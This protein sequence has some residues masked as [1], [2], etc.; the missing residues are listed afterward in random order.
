M[1]YQSRVMDA[2]EAF[3]YLCRGGCGYCVYVYIT[4]DGEVLQFDGEKLADCLIQR[5]GF[6]REAGLEA[7]E[8]LHINGRPDMEQ[9]Y[10][11]I[12]Q[13]IMEA[14]GMLQEALD[15]LE[16]EVAAS[17]NDVQKAFGQ[18][19]Q[20]LLRFSGDERLAEKVLQ[21]GESLA[22]LYDAMFSLAKKR[23]KGNVGGVGTQDIYDYYK[24]PTMQGMSQA[25]QR[26]PETKPQTSAGRRKVISLLDEL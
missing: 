1:S 10:M 9:Q 11:K 13:E 8:R 19:L 15:K 2:H 14:S 12:R 23:R 22:K 6:L 21:Q 7:Q 4:Q 3:L 25:P 5:D 20:A 26:E 16:R 24:I 17:K 18:E